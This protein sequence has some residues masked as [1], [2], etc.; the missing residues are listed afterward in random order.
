MG[1]NGAQWRIVSG[2]VAGRSYDESSSSSSLLRAKLNTPFDELAAGTH[3]LVLVL[4]EAPAHALAA[5]SALSSGRW[6][7][8]CRNPS[9]SALVNCSLL[10]SSLSDICSQ[11]GILDFIFVANYDLFPDGYLKARE[12]L[13]KF[14]IK[15]FFRCS[16]IFY[17]SRQWKLNKILTSYTYLPEI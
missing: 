14:R 3:V 16:K 5:H 15:S 7:R 1:H 2:K 8:S 13:V 4:F 6:P 10:P 17:R 11:L 12:I 9:T